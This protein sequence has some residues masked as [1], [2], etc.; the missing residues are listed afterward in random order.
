M[1]AYVQHKYGSSETLNI[2]EVKTP[3]IGADEILVQIKAVSLNPADWHM[4]RAKPSFIRLMSGLFKPKKKIIGSDFAGKV[5]S[6]GANVSAYK[7]GDEVFG[8]ATSGS[9]AEYNKVK[10]NMLALKPENSSY[11]EAACL[12]IAGLTALQ[13]IRDHGKLAAGEK[14]LING[15]SGGVGHYCVQIAKALGGHVTAVCSAKNS[16]FVKSLGADEVIDYTTTNI[17]SHQAHFDLTVDVHG[18]LNFKDFKRFAGKN[19]RAVMIGFTGMGHMLKVLASKAVSKSNIAQFTASAKSED[20]QY[21]A[22]LYK[23]GQ[24]KS[25]IE[26]TYSFNQLPEAI[27]YIEQMHTQGKVAVSV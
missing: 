18:N 16:D 10:L 24:L 13:G 17:H 20:L 7:V 12:G 4:M 25:S 2:E 21:L 19:G 23:D 26:R 15:A 1:K 11:Q 8:E 27:S 3:L 22:Q 6:V 14:V 5:V 9:F